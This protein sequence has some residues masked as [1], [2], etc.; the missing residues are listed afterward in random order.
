MHKIKKVLWTE[1]SHVATNLEVSISLNL[2][3]KRITVEKNSFN[4][5]M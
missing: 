3:N 1:N 5:Y 4:A 2:R